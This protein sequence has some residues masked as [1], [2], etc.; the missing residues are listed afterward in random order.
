MKPSIT[1]DELAEEL[2]R[3]GL[4]KSASALPAPNTER[5]WFISLV[6]GC[7]GW[8]AGV[9]VLAFIWL[10]FRPESPADNA[11]AGLVLVL[12]AFGLYTVDRRS[13]F[14]DQL[15]LALSIA[16]QFS[17]VLFAWDVVD[18]DALAATLTAVLQLI[19]L[20]VMPN[21]LAKLLSGFFGCCA[22]ALAIR[23]AVWGDDHRQATFLPVLFAWLIAWIPLIIAAHVLVATERAWIADRWSRIARPALHGLLL[24]LCLATWISEP[25][26]AVRFWDEGRASPNWLVL[27]PLLGVASALFAMLCAYRL[28]NRA[29]IGVAIAGALLHVAQFYYLLGATL[30]VKSCIMLGIGAAALWGAHWLRSRDVTNAG[31]AS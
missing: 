29:I 28:R 19:L 14:F 17:L 8:L 31:E 13:E 21:A 1:A 26:V 18:S 23:F 15:A 9:F 10:L 30:L 2:L 6:V 7:S 16:G 5:P 22:W 20:L 12:A 11:M 4:I 24:S 25:I 27:W 3:R